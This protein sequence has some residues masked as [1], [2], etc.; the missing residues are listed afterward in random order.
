MSPPLANI[1]LIDFL[2]AFRSS[3]LALKQQPLG[4]TY[5]AAEPKPSTTRPCFFP[6]ET[7]NMNLYLDQ[8]GFYR[9]LHKRWDIMDVEF[10]HYLRPVFL[11]RSGAYDQPLRRL[12]RGLPL[13]EM[14][15]DFLLTVAQETKQWITLR[16]GTEQPLNDQRHD[17]RAQVSL[18]PRDRA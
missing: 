4:F 6:F 1:S 7:A 3:C 15:E 9:G 2:L 14:L 18:P 17:T 11:Y 12:S 8:A 10:L 5:F 13:A 16:V